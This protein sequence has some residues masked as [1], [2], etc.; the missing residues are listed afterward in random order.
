MKW[1]LLSIGTVS[2]TQYSLPSLL[3]LRKAAFFA[4]LLFLLSVLCFGSVS[5]VSAQ[6]DSRPN[7]LFIMSDDHCARAMGI[8]GSRLAP[9]NPTPN[10][11]ALARQGMV[12]DNVFCTNSIC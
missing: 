11:D 7:I 8:Y 3:R 10:L 9:L 6:T 12:F 2:D 1:P 4:C 5:T